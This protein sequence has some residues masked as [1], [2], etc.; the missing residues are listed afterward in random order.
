ML[1]LTEVLEP[2]AAWFRS[3]NLPEPIIHWGHPVMMGIVIFVMGSFVG[4][5]GWRSRLLKEED[6]DAALENSSYHR[7]LAPWMFLFI[8]LGSTGGI[9][10]LV[11]QHQPIME[12]PHFWT[13]AV[14]LTLLAVNAVIALSKFGGDKANLR[15]VH[16]YLGSIA[17]GILFVH[18]FLGLN[19]GMSF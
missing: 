6:K 18:A 10:S 17:L 9:L 14:V 13:G 2:I 15:T 12:S 7:K 3:F 8:S 5:S 19:L 11:M 1:N 16:A 4:W